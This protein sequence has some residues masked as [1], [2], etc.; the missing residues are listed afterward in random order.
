MAGFGPPPRGLG[1]R[2]HVAG[3]QGLDGLGQAAGLHVLG[4]LSDGEVDELAHAG[5][6]DPVEFRLALLGEAEV[7]QHDPAAGLDQHV[8]P[9]GDQR[10]R[11]FDSKNGKELWVTKLSHTATAVPMSFAGKSGK[12]YVAIITGGGAPHTTDSINLTPEVKNPIFRTS[13][14]WVFQVN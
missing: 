3:E 9:R 8:V 5:G 13:S 14:I 4:R 11:A 7:E 2:G 10:F 1:D 12:Q 6:R